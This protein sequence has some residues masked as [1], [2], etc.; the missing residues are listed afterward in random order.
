MPVSSVPPTAVLKPQVSAV[1]TTTP[2]LP[3]PIASTFPVYD[4][5]C[6]TGWRPGHRG[7][8]SLTVGNRQRTVNV[9]V[10]S[11][12]RPGTPAPLLLDV[13]GHETN[14]VSALETHGFVRLA[15]RDGAVVVAPDG[16][17]LDDIQATGWSYLDDVQRND[18]AFIDALL[19][20]VEQ[21]V[22][23]DALRFWAVGHS[24]GGGFVGLLMC[25]LPNRFAAFGSYGAA[26]YDTCPNNVRAPVIEVHGGNDTVV[27]YN[28]VYRWIQGWVGRNNCSRSATETVESIGVRHLEWACPDDSVLGPLAVEHVIA[29]G[30]PHDWPDAEGGFRPAEVIWEF[31]T[32]YSRS[33]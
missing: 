21:Q 14:G 4:A 8:I 24:N 12:Y 33:S 20:Y 2:L 23:V 31:I 7:S 13:H 32:R 3:P 6:A 15:E 30:Y 26:F 11:T 17:F 16:T 5:K 19:V 9:V 22:C 25:R 29:G 10:P 1:T 18:V 27:D 28:G